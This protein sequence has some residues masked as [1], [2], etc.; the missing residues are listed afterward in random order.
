MRIHP[1]C[2][3]IRVEASEGIGIR[4][5]RLEGISDGIMAVAITLLALGIEAPTPKPGESLLQA[6]DAQTLGA[7]GL[8]ALSFFLIARFWLVHHRLFAGLP[9]TLAPPFVILNFAFLAA[10]CLVPFATTTYSR[11]P[12]DMT[13][14]VIYTVVVAGATI[15]LSFMFRQSATSTTRRGVIVPLI[16]LSAI[17]VGLLVG[18]RYAPLVW[19]LLLL[20][21]G[22]RAARLSRRRS[23]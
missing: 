9:S 12:D 17:P 20:A 16:L 19:I 10:I 11:N 4:R 18:P 21:D 15:L 13:A 8:F 22:S 6:F 7:I 23:A 3:A 2:D 14:L 5:G 1:A